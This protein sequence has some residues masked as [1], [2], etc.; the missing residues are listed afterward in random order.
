[1]SLNPSYRTTLF[2]PLF[3]VRGDH[4]RHLDRSLFYGVNFVNFLPFLWC[5]ECADSSPFF[6]VSDLSD[7]SLFY[8]LGKL[9]NI[10][11]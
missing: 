10:E 3:K 7:F 5:A 9:G 11:P 2:F 4:G 6:I 1:M 8:G